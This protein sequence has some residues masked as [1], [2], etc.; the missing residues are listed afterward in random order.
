MEGQEKIAEIL[1]ATEERMSKTLESAKKEFAKVR[2]G[3]ASIHL[4]DDIKVEAYDSLLPLNQVSTITTPENNLILIQVWDKNVV[5][6]VEKAIRTSGLGFNPVIEG[7]VLKIPVPPLTEERRK[8]LVK[9]IKKHAEDFR[10]AIRNIRRDANE[11]IKKLEK[12]KEISED[13]MHRTL[14][15]IQQFTKKYTEEIDELLEKKEK[16]IMSI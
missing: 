8:E 4:L 13:D 16:E 6:A 11:R 10:V 5:P 12:N 15:K 7:T 9:F 3:R 1:K 2:T 14:D